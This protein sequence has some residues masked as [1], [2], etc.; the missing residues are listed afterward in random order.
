MGV[1][2]FR[3]FDI[4]DRDC[5]MKICSD[6]VTFGAWFL[7]CHSDAR[8]VLDIGAGSGLLSL[9]AAQCMPGA[10]IKGIEID[11]GAAE[12]SRHNFGTSPWARRLVIENLDFADFHPSESADIILSNPPFFT[13]G[14]L[15]PDSRRATAR[16]ESTLTITT[17]LSFA[18]SHLV[19]SGHLGLI[20]PAERTDDTIFQAE[21]AG[22]K[23]RRLAR[24]VAREGRQPVRALFDFSPTD[25]TVSEETIIMRGRDGIPTSHYISIVEPFYTKIS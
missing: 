5:G 11:N 25:G 19:K 15:A 21:L 24:V 2:H 13:T 6:S 22:L 10:A 3:Q 8:S 12:A 14:L 1:F 17:L 23:L 20:L 9:M 18:R 16:H 4:E 7:P